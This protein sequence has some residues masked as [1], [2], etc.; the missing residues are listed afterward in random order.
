LIKETDKNGHY[1][2]IVESKISKTKKQM[3]AKKMEMMKRKHATHRGDIRL[4]N[5]RDK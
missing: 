4:T 3:E 5:P 2:I 1:N